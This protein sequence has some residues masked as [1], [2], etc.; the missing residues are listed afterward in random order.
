[1]VVIN[2]WGQ[3]AGSMIN[4]LISTEEGAAFLVER[5][6]RD[7]ERNG[8]YL[9]HLDSTCQ[10]GNQTGSRI[11]AFQQF[12]KAIT[13]AWMEEPA[14]VHINPESNDILAHQFYSP[15]GEQQRGWVVVVNAKQAFFL[16]PLATIKQRVFWYA[17]LVLALAL[18]AATFFSRSLVQP[19][20]NVIDGVRQMSN[21]LNNRIEVASQDEVGFMA[22]EINRMAA[23]LQQNI[24]EKQRVELQVC[25]AEKLA[26]IGEMAAGLAHELNTPLNNI[27]ALASLSKKELAEQRIDPAALKTDLEDISEQTGKCSQIISGLL[28]F[29]RN[30]AP[31][32]DL[33]D[34][35]RLLDDALAL[36]RLRQQQKEIRIELERNEQLPP[37]TVDGTQ[38]QQVFV[39]LLLNAL[40]AMEPGGSIH[41]WPRQETD[42]KL[43]ISFKDDGCGIPAE[44]QCRIFDPFF[45][46]KEVGKGTGLGLSVSYGILKNHGG[47]IDVKSVPGQ[48]AEFNVSL[49]IGGV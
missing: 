24:E 9:F 19:I 21:D 26:S 29:S 16:K 17:A 47:S 31:D 30:Q 41:I 6:L 40:D 38:I 43:S 10:F 3:T 44:Q 11:T 39:N 18:V 15:Y 13:T 27:H 45:T 25:H 22:G 14:G 12:P 20:R 37:I 1:V 8:I 48:G 42:G 46:T 4:R 49:P 34:V 5:N 36:I 23:S 35:N 2:V 28:S 32:R 33:H 7:P